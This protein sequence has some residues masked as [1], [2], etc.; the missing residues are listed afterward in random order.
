MAIMD[1]ENRIPQILWEIYAHNKTVQQAV[2][3]FCSVYWDRPR[4]ARRIGANG[5]FTVYGGRR[6]YNIK[7]VDNIPSVYRIVV[8]REG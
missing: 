8:V 2:N 4:R 3:E 6:M 1:R 7:L 5:D